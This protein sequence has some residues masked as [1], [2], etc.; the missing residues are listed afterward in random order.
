MNPSF[1]SSSQQQKLGLTYDQ[2]VKFSS[3]NRYWKKTVDNSF[4]FYADDKKIGTMDFYFGQST[5]TAEFRI[6]S[7]S[8]TISRKGFW[9]SALLIKDATGSTVL[10]V[11]AEKWY[12]HQWV[13]L[14]ANKTYA[15]K[16]RNHPLAEYVIT[17]GDTEILA[18]GLKV[19]DGNVQVAITC[20]ASNSPYLFDALLWFLFAPVAIENMGDEIS[21]AL[22]LAQ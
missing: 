20:A 3:M 7:E 2:V 1:N 10:K 22:L 16:V 17:D 5:Q 12:A 19:I 8:F 21:F 9:N 14:H 4:D 6:G 11:A 15:L 18:C 13:L